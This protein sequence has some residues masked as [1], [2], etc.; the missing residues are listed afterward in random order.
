MRSFLQADASPTSPSAGPFSP[1]ALR[2]VRSAFPFSPIHLP[3]VPS[4]HPHY[5]DFPATMAALTPAALLSTRRCD[6]SPCF[7]LPAFLTLPS[8]TTPGTPLAA[9]THYPSARSVPSRL[10]HSLAGSPM[11]TAES[12]SLSY[13]RVV[14]LRLLPTLPHGNA[15]IFGYGPESAYPERTLTSLSESAPRRTSGGILPPNKIMWGET[16][17][18]LFARR[19]QATFFHPA[20]SRASADAWVPHCLQWEPTA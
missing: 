3:A 14:H 13:G 2:P 5:R 9:F 15:V 8:P 16:P 4:L 1:G 12:S 17:H 7:T 20:S 19:S 6:R 11:P 10:R 18:L